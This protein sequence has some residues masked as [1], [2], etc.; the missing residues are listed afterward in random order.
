MY[1]H[2]PITRQL[3][4]RAL[5]IEYVQLPSD[6]REIAGL[7][8]L[9]WIGVTLAG[10]SESLPR[11]LID[12]AIADGGRPLSTLVGHSE[13][14][15]PLQ[16][17]L[18]NGSASHVLDYDD[19]NPTVILHG[20]AS[21]LPG[22]FA[23]AEVEDVNGPELVA[24][25]V[26]GYETGCRVAL[27]LQPGHYARGYHNT[28]TI[29]TLAAAVACAHLLKL[30]PQRTAHAVGIAAT[31]AG[32]LKSMFG[33]QCKAFHAGLASHNGLRAARLSASGMT[34]RPDIL[35]C[36]NGFATTMSPN[37]N[38]IAALAHPEQFH[39]RHN[40]F[41]HHASCGGTHAAIECVR[42]LYASAVFDVRDI[43]RV[44]VRVDQTMDAM[45]NIAAPKTGLEAK[46]SLR[47]MTAAALLRADTAGIALYDDEYAR[48][49]P[50]C[51]LRDKVT[52]ELIVDWPKMQAEV[53]VVLSDGR[54]LRA[55]HDAGLPPNDYVREGEQ[56]RAKF[57]RL[58]MPV[59]GAA[60]AAAIIESVAQLE[61]TSAIALMASCS[62]VPKYR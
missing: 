40:V 9:D 8:V 41:K 32:G 3:V 10:S 47:F 20:S 28:S 21:I 5:A 57:E 23:L 24:A 26:A 12:E 35:E 39:M 48:S 49:A 4:E 42:E 34:A 6:V 33:T 15:T 56:L 55:T 53:I 36:P 18:I 46:F 7:C 59:V 51:A 22:L 60:R 2:A 52:V 38:P 13:R 1:E 45:C 29:G 58:A 27:L 14:V 54:T 43:E 25:F 61:R 30:D 31:E 19:G 50:L 37:F 16:A 62:A 44:T 11:L 17:A